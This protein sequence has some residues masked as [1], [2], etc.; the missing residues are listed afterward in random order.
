MNAGARLSELRELI[1]YHNHRYHVL[2][3]PELADAEYD[4]L[5]DELLALEAAHPELITA[6]SPS[7]RV[8]SAPLGE[9]ASVAHERPML[10]LD[11]C[12]TPEELA[13]WLQRCR[14]RIPDEPITLTCEP[15]IDGVAVAL[16]YEQGVLTL[17]ATRGDGTTGEDITANV[18]TIGAVPLKVPA[19]DVPDR[20]E[21]RGEIYMPLEDFEAFNEAARISGGKTLVNPRNG[22]AGSLRQLDPS[23]TAARPLTMFCYSLGWTEG[24]WQPTTHI[25]VLEQFRRW[26][27]RVSDD[28]VSCEDLD[29]AQQ[30]LDGLLKRRAQLGFDIDGAV[31]KV[32]SLDQQARLGA[33]TR[34][35]RW[36]MA[37]KYPPEEATTT[38]QDVEFQVGRTGAVTPGG[39]A[40]TGV[41]RRGHR[42][43][44]NAA[45][46]GGN[47]P[48]GCADWRH[49]DGASRR[50]CD[51]PGYRCDSE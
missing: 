20:M 48:S 42:K 14:N 35:P 27:F 16:I 51:S 36:A 37:Y 38:L 26:G 45:Q 17:A 39:P 7:Q 21:V 12:T 8:G 44:R 2:D 28:V 41:C 6:D 31:V 5:F 23:L 40:R 15:K 18:R 29:A 47:R 33:V 25:E 43:Q 49:G 34:K 19:E 46:H 10:S 3:D 13:D 24:D 32:N 11:K 50:G 30:Y 1:H 4:A 22:A 9:F